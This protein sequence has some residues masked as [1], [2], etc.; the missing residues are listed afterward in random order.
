MVVN[1]LGISTFVNPYIYVVFVLLL[2]I[3]IKP[4][5]VLIISCLTG[6]VMDSFSSTPGLHMAACVCMGYLRGFYL[7]FATGK[8]DQESNIIPNLSNK[9]WVWF[10]FYTFIM[11]FI[12]HF[13]LFFLEIYELN[14]F[15]STILEIFSSTLFSVFIIIVGQLLFYKISITKSQIL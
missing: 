13:I 6:M 10:S 2:P 4:W 1:K 7:R 5:V 15:F 3:K 14:Q 8:D 11:I 12:H 9:G